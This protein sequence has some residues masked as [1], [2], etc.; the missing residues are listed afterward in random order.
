MPVSCSAGGSAYSA[1]GA[2]RLINDNGGTCAAL[3]APFPSDGGVPGASCSV[4]SD[5]ALVCCGCSNPSWI[6]ATGVC[7]QGH[8]AAPAAACAWGYAQDPLVC[9]PP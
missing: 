1:T 2:I 7:A 9:G 4:S 8:C 3:E 6:F 5:C